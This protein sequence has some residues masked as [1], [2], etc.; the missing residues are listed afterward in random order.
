MVVYIQN[1]S[2]KL[3]VDELV[4]GGIV[5]LC[6]KSTDG[7]DGVNVIN[8]WDTGRM[9]QQ[10]FYGNED[11]SFWNGRKWTWNPVQGGSWDGQTSKL[12]SLN[13]ISERE[14]VVKT[15]PRN[16]GGCELCSD[17]IMTTCIIIGEE[18][19]V[20]S[21]APIVRVK[22]TMEY[23]GI[24]KHKPRVQEIPACFLIA[25]YSR[26]VYK[27]SKTSRVVKELPGPPGI[28]CTRGKA[29][30]KWVGYVNPDTCEAVFLRSPSATSLTVYRVDIPNNPRESN[31]SYMAPLMTCGFKGPSEVSY[32]F[33]IELCRYDLANAVERT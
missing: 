6:K 2:I 26:L 24:M 8:T 18:N 20:E 32:G 11:G 16:W 25:S 27:E 4:G 19:E 21:I 14:L 33:T 9:I 7:K 22:C 12:L 15:M 10:S 23:K 17:V 3:G 28:K 30:P 31:C 5:F 13:K 29:D 1:K